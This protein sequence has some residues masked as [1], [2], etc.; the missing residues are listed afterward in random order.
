MFEPLLVILGRKY[1]SSHY[2]A[3]GATVF[4]A[5]QFVLNLDPLTPDCA[6]YRD[7]QLSVITSDGVAFVAQFWQVLF[8]EGGINSIWAPAV[9]PFRH[10]LERIFVLAAQ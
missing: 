10:P 3:A 6:H 9:A 8:H 2:V 7:I 4:K 1:A 5:T